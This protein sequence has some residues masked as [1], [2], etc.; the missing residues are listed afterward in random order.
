MSHDLFITHAWRY[1]DDWTR[2]SDLLDRA[3]IRWR[4][5]SVPWH[6][7][8]MSANSRTGGEFIRSWLESQII[9][10]HGVIFL[11]SVYAVSSACKWLDLELE[12][13]RKHG[14]PVV[15]LPPHGQTEVSETVR[16]RVDA[17]V[18]WDAGEIIG[19]FARL[20]TA[21]QERRAEPSGEAHP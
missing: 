14:K 6:D 4:N 9:P 15:A 5:F 13:A 8:A 3:G 11:D 21:A 1:H 2:V 20:R 12:M 17:V 10:V 16:R 19:A 18:P 7:P